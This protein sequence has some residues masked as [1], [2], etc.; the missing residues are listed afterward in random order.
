MDNIF[1]ISQ[2]KIDIFSLLMRR[3][4]FIVY[5]KKYENTSKRVN[6]NHMTKSR[7]FILLASDYILSNDF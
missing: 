6:E 1:E 4:T 5:E 7:R 2:N 3:G